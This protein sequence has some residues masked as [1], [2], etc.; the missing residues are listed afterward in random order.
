VSSSNVREAILTTASELFYRDGV[1]AVGVDTIIAEAGVAK[2]SLYRHF[3]TKDELIAAYVQ[4]EDDAFW[5]GWD[6]VASQHHGSPRDALVALLT[7][8]GT[9]IAA[10]G[11][12]GCPQ[13]NVAVEFPDVTH[14]ARRIAANHKSELRRRLGNLARGLPASNPELIADQLWLLIDGAFINHDLMA[15]RDPVAVLINAVQAILPAAEE[16]SRRRSAPPPSTTS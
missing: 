2:S 10:P 13:L 3:R 5:Q 14:P 11:F 12:R 8:I 9:K 4:L 6:A 1:H 15:D 16:P 7:W